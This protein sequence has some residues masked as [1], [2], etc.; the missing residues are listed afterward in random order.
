MFLRD[1]NVKTAQSG[2]LKN[3]IFFFIHSK[4]TEAN[5]RRKFL[6]YNYTTL[7]QTV[8]NLAEILWRLERFAR[9]TARR[10]IGD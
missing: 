8:K 4:P 7:T 5:I 1:A 9:K 2:L 6:S 3:P 10:P